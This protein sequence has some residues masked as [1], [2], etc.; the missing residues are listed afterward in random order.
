[1]NSS[2]TQDILE[3]EMTDFGPIVEAK[4]DLRPMTVFVGP[5]NTGKSYMAIL[6]Y[7]LHQYFN[8]L[9]DSR[10]LNPNRKIPRGTVESI[11]TLAEQISRNKKKNSS[12]EDII[13][14]NLVVDTIRSRLATQGNQLHKEI[15]RCFGIEDTVR[16]VRKGTKGVASINFR[17]RN[18]N[19][20]EQI[21]HQL[22]LSATPCEF[23]TIIPKGTQMRLRTVDYDYHF[24]HSHLTLRNM[25]EEMASL[26]SLRKEKEK[27]LDSFI[28]YFL[29]TLIDH[30]RSQII[31]P[32]CLPAFYLPA[33]RTGIMH[34]HSVVVSALIGSAAMAG[35]RPTTRTPVVSGVLADFL[36]L[37]I[38][39][40]RTQRKTRHGLDKQ[41]EKTILGGSVGVD[42][43][44]LIDYPQFTYRPKGWEN[45]LSLMN[46][47]SMV[48]E[49]TPVVLYLR[50]IVKPGNVLIV[51]EP[52]SHLHPAMQVEFTRQLAALVKKGIRV[53]ITTHSEWVLEEIANVVGRSK[54]PKLNQKT[55]D[56]AK[57][58]LNP[59]QVGVW[60][61]NQKKRPKGSVV[62]EIRL[63]HETGL[64]PTDYDVVSEELYNENVDIFN[65]TQN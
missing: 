54:L 31:G 58:A 10:M 20:S 55:D 6:I 34:A 1:M 21:N 61:F 52:E 18:T 13:L 35:I 16:L 8:F 14:P 17:G 43:S 65:R 53:I 7:A 24:R 25:A 40:G 19:E 56:I 49:L 50:Y 32:L 11:I 46:T 9:A 27:R 64:Y 12:G 28:R 44:K 23:K 39:F 36:E 57:T 5:S 30:F 38:E 63:D 15:S 26:T 60:L 22:T 2:S 51:E 62:E 42:K 37:L 3:L 4:I 33:D 45:N 59:N 47:S 29:D 41:I 48:L